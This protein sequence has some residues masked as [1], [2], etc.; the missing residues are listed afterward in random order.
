M[1]TFFKSIKSPVSEYSIVIEDDGKVAYAYL[2][3]NKAIISD[4]WLYN[5]A[6]TPGDPEWKG[7]GTP[8]FL[9][10]A[11]F[12]LFEL[13]ATPLMNDSKMDVRW[14]LNNSGEVTGVTILLNGSPY[15]VLR[16]GAKP[17]WNIAAKDGPLAKNLRTK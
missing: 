10:P 15:G 7:R 13:M 2:L 4:L 14:E 8:P 9:N 5:Q 12:V 6:E 16:P 17:A 1:S 3:K 11:K